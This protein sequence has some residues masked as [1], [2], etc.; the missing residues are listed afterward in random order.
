M[1]KYGILMTITLILTP[2]VTYH[3][4]ILIFKDPDS[5]A[6]EPKVYHEIKWEVNTDT[7]T[8]LGPKCGLLWLNLDYEVCM[9]TTLPQL[10]IGL[11]ISQSRDILTFDGYK[12]ED[13]PEGINVYERPCYGDSGSGHWITESDR[14]IAVAILSSVQQPCG[15]VWIGPPY[16]GTKLNKITNRIIHE[17][18]K[19]KASI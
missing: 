12:N 13:P 18:I 5:S 2:R 3:S 10:R 9:K 4:L 11:F 19:E 14:A 15:N 1:P 8:A 16:S 7:H 6:N 17:W